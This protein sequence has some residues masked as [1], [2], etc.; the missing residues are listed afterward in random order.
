MNSA[1]LLAMV[2]TGRNRGINAIVD[3]KRPMSVKPAYRGRFNRLILYQTTLQ[4]D[5]EYIE[6]WI[7]SG[8]GSMAK[9]KELKNGEFIEVDLDQQ[10]VSDVK[11]L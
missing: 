2:T 5:I 4:D 11:R 1:V 8:R 10:T 9:L 7:G 6:D 3:A